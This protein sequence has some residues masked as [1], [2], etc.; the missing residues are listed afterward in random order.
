MKNSLLTLGKVLDKTQLKQIN[1]GFAV[2]DYSNDCDSGHHHEYHH[3][4]WYCVR[5]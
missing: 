3:P 2:L 4:Y 5:D 1:A